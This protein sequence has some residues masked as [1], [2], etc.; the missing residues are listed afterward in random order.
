MTD[1]Q[2]AVPADEAAQ[3]E[4]NPAGEAPEAAAPAEQAGDAQADCGGCGCAA[5]R[6]NGASWA[7]TPFWR[8]PS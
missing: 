1:S 3:L 4:I 6:L 2:D 7:I 8:L 5:V